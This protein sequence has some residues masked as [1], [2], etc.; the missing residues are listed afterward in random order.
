MFFNSGLKLE[1]ETAQNKVKSLD[2]ENGELKNQIRLLNGKLLNSDA[3]NKSL[4]QELDKLKGEITSLQELNNKE[5]FLDSNDEKVTKLFKYQ[6]ENLK[7][8]LLDIQ[9][10][11]SESTELART[12]LSES[13]KING[14]YEDSKNKLNIIVN[15]IASLNTNATDINNVVTDLNTKASDIADAV[16]T[17]DQISFQTNILSLNAAVEAATAG[18]AGKGF[19]VVAQEVR[20]LATR[21]AEAAK[22]I[23]KVVNSIQES[24]EQTNQK[25]AIMTKA[26]DNISNETITYS[27]NIHEVM[28]T[29]KETFS[30]LGHITDRIFMSLAKLDHVIWKVN[31]YLSVA[32]KE[33][34]FAFV[35]HKNCRLG[36]WYNEGLGKKYFASTPSYSKL[37]IPHSK[38]H[39]GT[40][41]VFDE[42]EKENLDY[43]ALLASF[44]EMET[45]SDEVF[46]LLDKILH[47]RD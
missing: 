8:G 25:F 17:I 15:D 22:E 45:A 14:T 3:K 36:K 18:E 26:I 41:H 27:G 31:T 2:K 46:S 4:E 28:E 47:E 23:T 40:H 19:A 38:V 34:A 5:S 7:K 37:D 6:N 13:Y 44:K 21:S 20:N 12:N 35:D 33:P 11:I 39:N 43:D 30:G 32:N 24:V 16:V 9:A 29:S 42:I 10:N 1:L